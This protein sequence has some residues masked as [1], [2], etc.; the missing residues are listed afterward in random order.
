MSVLLISSLDFC[1]C[2]DIN[3]EFLFLLGE[4]STN[5]LKMYYFRHVNAKLFDALTMVTITNCKWSSSR[6][7]LTSGHSLLILLVKV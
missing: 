4:T 1:V 2:E 6:C 7:F 3:V 5:S